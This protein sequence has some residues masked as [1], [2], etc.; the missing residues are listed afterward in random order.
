MFHDCNRR[1]GGRLRRALADKELSLLLAEVAANGPHVV[2]ILDCC[3]SGG[4]TRD[5]FV[6]TR[7]WMPD[8]DN[9]EAGL[10]RPRR[11]R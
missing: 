7:G 1:V 9:A 6:R 3:H 4:G 10:A 5:P 2:V 11:R 8:V